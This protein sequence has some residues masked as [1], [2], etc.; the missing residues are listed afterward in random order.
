[1]TENAQANELILDCPI[2]LSLLHRPLT[3]YCGHR[4]FFPL[5]PKN[6]YEFSFCEQCIAM[7]SYNKQNGVCPVCRQQI[8]LKISVR[9]QYINFL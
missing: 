6:Y 1:M 3:L 7:H 8:T 5:F 2:C 9:N 4:Y